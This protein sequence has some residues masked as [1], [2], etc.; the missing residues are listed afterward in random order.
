MAPLPHLD[1][2][3]VAQHEPRVG[4][5][6][7]LGVVGDEDDRRARVRWMSRSSSMMCRP[8]GAVEIAGR[9]VGQDDRRIVGQRARQRHA[10]LFAARQLR[11]IV[12]R[13]P[14][15]A[16]FLE[17]RA[18]RVRGS[19]TPA[20]SI[21]TATFSYAVSDGNQV[22]ELKDEADLLAAQPRQR[23]LAEPRDVDAVDQHRSGGR[24]IEAGDEAEQRRLAAARR[25]D[26]GEELAARESCSVSG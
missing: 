25:P 1:D 8:F 6:R 4:H 12:M 24:R 11:R 22:E 7:Q 13:A 9:L 18:A 10:L 15:Q 23:V 16:D 5:R 26:D 14:G 20:I 19:A 2:A 17:Q 21:G 3:A